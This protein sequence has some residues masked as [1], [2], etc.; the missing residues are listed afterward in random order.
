MCPF[1]GNSM[2]PPEDRMAVTAEEGEILSSRWISAAIRWRISDIEIVMSQLRE[3]RA[4]EKECT[5]KTERI[6]S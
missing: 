4:A 5:G 1:A 3:K 6:S 2:F